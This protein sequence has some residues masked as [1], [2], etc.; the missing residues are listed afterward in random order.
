[1]IK[2]ISNKGPYRSLANLESVLPK[3]KQ[4]KLPE[5]FAWRFLAGEIFAGI[6]SWFCMFSYFLVFKS[7]DLTD[8]MFS[9][10]GCFFSYLACAY[11]L[12]IVEGQ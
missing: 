9:L 8:I 11:L 12:P 3:K 1:M 4:W 7:R 2:I 5:D 10:I 6:M